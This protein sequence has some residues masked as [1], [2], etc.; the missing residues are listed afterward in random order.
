[1]TK[2]ALLVQ[3]LQ[4]F[5]TYLEPLM[6]HPDHLEKLNHFRT[7]EQVLP[8]LVQLKAV[9][10][11]GGLN[12]AA[13]NFCNELAISDPAVVKKIKLYLGCFVDLSS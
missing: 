3:K 2:E 13:T 9:C 11:A 1:M 5:R 8:Y 12:A 4:N 7:L 6:S 10:A